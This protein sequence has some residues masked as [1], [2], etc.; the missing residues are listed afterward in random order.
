MTVD[1]REVEFAEGCS[2]AAVLLSVG[3]VAT[4]RSPRR[5]EPRGHYCGMGVCFE[6]VVRIDGCSDRRACLTEARDG[7]VV[8]TA[9]S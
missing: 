2:V 4:R 7:M 1:G 8:E 5:Q 9:A 3:L 6:C